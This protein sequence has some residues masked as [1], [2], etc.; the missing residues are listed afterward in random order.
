MASL[1]AN[2]T[3]TRPPAHAATRSSGAHMGKFTDALNDVTPEIAP[4]PP[5][6]FF[7]FI[8]KYWH[9]IIPE[10][11]H[12]NWHIE[13]I[14]GEMQAMAERVFK[15]LPKEHDLIINVSPGSTKSTVC[16]VMFPVW[17]WTVDQSIRS[18]CGS[19]AFPLSLH[20]ATQSRNILR[21]DEFKRRYPEIILDETQKGLLT[22]TGRGQRI[23]TS[24]GGSITGMH[25]HFLIVDDPINPK[26]AVS[27]T[28]LQAANDWIDQTLM[29]RK[30]D[31]AITPTILIMQRL[32]QN[33]PTGHLLSKRDQ[34]TI[35]HICLPAVIT[36]DVQPKS[37]RQ[38][39]TDG[40]MDIDRLGPDVLKESKN[41]LGEYGYAGQFLQSPIPPGGGMFKTEYVRLGAPPRKFA[42][43]V[44]YWDKAGTVDGGAYTVG[45]LLGKDL[46]GKFWVLDIIRGQWEARE[47][48]DI[49]LRTARMDG[50]GVIVGI[51]QEPGSGGKESAQATVRNLVGFRVRVDRPTGNKVL[52]ADPF[53]VQVNGGNVFM[54]W[55][56]WNRTY[57]DELSFF[58][59][60]TY[61]DQ[62]DSS[63]AAFSILAMSNKRIGA[64]K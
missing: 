15:R 8:K 47:R 25:G 2:Y 55:G 26:E 36:K 57:L 11:P 22:N 29:T 45:A 63:S 54:V 41:N 23:A 10:A 16:S 43:R 39:Y 42:M 52:R 14:C 62:C 7:R 32:H 9:T 56:E 64:L 46:A 24:T 37:L 61:K 50:E 33:D 4:V 49:I 59:H 13:Y 5:G 40:H 44:R 60:S 6:A 12:W 38:Y 27:K 35:R 28:Q 58:P 21:S 53:A 31:K 19:Y 1:I 51:E 17:C 3:A 30:I 20:L 18:I 48:E 34:D